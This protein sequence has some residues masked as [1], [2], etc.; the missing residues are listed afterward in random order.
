MNPETREKNVQVSMELPESV[1]EVLLS[2]TT[3]ELKRK[4]IAENGLTIA[5]EESILKQKANL[6]I[7]ATLKT[8]RDIEDHFNKLSE[9]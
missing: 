9:G 8:E 4:V 7:T 2:S 5:E 1:A 6:D 3:E